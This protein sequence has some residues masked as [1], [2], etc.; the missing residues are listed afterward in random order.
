MAGGKCI[1]ASFLLSDSLYAVFPFFS[2]FIRLS[3]FKHPFGDL[4][5]LQAS[6]IAEAC[7]TAQGVK[8]SPGPDLKP[9]D[10]SKG[11]GQVLGLVISNLVFV[12]VV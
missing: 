3:S 1:Y 6:W 12:Q 11:G 2:P 9:H 4:P 5:T 10:H 8:P 7:H